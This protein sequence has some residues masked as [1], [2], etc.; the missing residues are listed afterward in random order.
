[1]FYGEY[2]CSG[3]G[4]NSNAR[5]AYVQKLN[6]T[7]VAPFLNLSYIEA[8]QWLENYTT[9]LILHSPTHSLTY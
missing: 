6:D 5:V 1:M 4:A 3:A 9:N 8:D 7:T 2:M